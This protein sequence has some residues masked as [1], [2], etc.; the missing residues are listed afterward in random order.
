MG[1]SLAAGSRAHV[2]GAGAGDINA[3]E[4][5][6]PHESV[7]PHV[8]EHQPVPSFQP[9]QGVSSEN[10]IQPVASGPNTVE[11]TSSLSAGPSIVSSPKAL[12][13]LPE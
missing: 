13:E 10:C 6:R 4:V 11:G 5:A 12:F 7:R 9:G 3:V 8:G 2:K 1:C